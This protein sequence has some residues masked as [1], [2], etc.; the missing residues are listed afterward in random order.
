MYGNLTSPKYMVCYMFSFTCGHLRHMERSPVQS[1]FHDLLSECQLWISYA[2]KQY[3]GGYATFHG[4]SLNQCKSKCLQ[5]PKCVTAT[6]IDYSSGPCYL[7]SKYARV[8][9]IGL[10]VH[11]VKSCPGIV[12]TLQDMKQS[13]NC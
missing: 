2:T 13:N 5:D 7:Q 6:W 10:N 9:A 1:S 3:G 8:V 4:Q 11:I 12:N